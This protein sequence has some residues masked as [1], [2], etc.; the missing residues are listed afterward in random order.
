MHKET[1]RRH[2]PVRSGHRRVRRSVQPGSDQDVLQARAM[3]ASRPLGCEAK[4]SSPANQYSILGNGM[5]QVN[6]CPVCGYRMA[7]PPDDYNICPCCGTEFGYSDSG[8]TYARLREEWIRSGARWWSPNHAAPP[9]WSPWLQMLMNLGSVT[10]SGTASDLHFDERLN[11]ESGTV[12]HCV[13]KAIS[14]AAIAYA[15]SQQAANPIQ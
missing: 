7:F 13:G 1:Q 11:P 10:A 9:G 14:P 8:T 12:A 3:F 6:V 4:L 2:R 5:Q 15:E